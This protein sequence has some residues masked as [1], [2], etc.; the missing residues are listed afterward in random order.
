MSVNIREI[1]FDSLLEWEEK[2]LKSHLLIRDVLAKYDY[3]DNTDKNFIKRLFEG[4]IQSMITLDHVLDKHSS[5]KMDK[6]KKMK[7]MEK[8]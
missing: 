2:D 3:L 7:N 1:V 6:C 4:C 8:I 5:K